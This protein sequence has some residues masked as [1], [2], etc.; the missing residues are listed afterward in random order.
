VEDVPGSLERF[1]GL[2]KAI[3]ITLIGAKVDCGG[4]QRLMSIIANYWA[5]KEWKV[6]LFILDGDST[7]P[8]FEL[9]PR[10]LLIHLDI[11]RPSS[12]ILEAIWNNLRR[13][14]ALR[15]VIRDSKPDVVVS[16][17]AFVNVLVLFATRGM[18]VPVVVTDPCD[19]KVEPLKWIFALLR[20]WT[21]TFDAQLVVETERAKASYAHKIQS[22]TTVIP[23]PITPI[24]QADKGL[25]EI[26][27]DRPSLVAIGRFQHNKGFDLL[28]NAF[29]R[30]K[31]Q[32]PDWTLTIIGDGPLRSYLESLR[33]ELGLDDRVHLPGFVDNI[34]HALKQADLFVM[35]SR[36]EGMPMALMEAM[37]CGL[38]VIS[39]DCRCG[40]REIIR[41]G[42]DGALVPPE[43][44]EALSAAM[45]QLMSDESARKR[46]AS[47]AV[48]VTERFSVEQVL[49][50]WEQ[51]LRSKVLDRDGR[52]EDQHTGR[53][54][55]AE[56]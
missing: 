20:R 39:T 29:A 14:Y 38:P 44:V 15:R 49:G 55:T 48:E 56:L 23:N 46:L 17:W 16:F 4:V 34:Y 50:R 8:F 37:S 26:T 2:E 22:R 43:N 28:L 21:Y 33:D 53:Q 40:P 45:D 25:P 10:I 18:R 31:D 13:I 27:L 6:T 51:L 5:Q 3:R 24:T 1:T 12:N 41:N 30:V 9:D 42:I 11:Y 35:S 54:V 7:S 52:D 32:Y 19:P 47:R 36:W